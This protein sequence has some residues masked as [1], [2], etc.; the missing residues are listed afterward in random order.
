LKGYSFLSLARQA[1]SGHKGWPVVWRSPEPKKNY[2][3]VIIGAG[4]Q[5]VVAAADDNSIVLCC[6]HR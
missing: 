4:G 1:L 6:G 2:D 3:V 5:A